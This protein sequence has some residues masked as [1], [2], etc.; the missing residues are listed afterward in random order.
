MNSNNLDV[1]AV[2]STFVLFLMI[3][4]AGRRLKDI[5]QSALLALLVLIPGVNLLFALYLAISN[6][7]NTKVYVPFGDDPYDPNSWVPNELPGATGSAVSY[8]GT[9]IYLPGEEDDSQQ[10]A[11]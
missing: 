10:Q 2:A 1:Y 8:Q 4:N 9:S 3:I 5:K 11:A 7:P 6:G